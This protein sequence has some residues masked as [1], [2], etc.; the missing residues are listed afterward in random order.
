MFVYTVSYHHSVCS[1]ILH[2]H[3]VQYTGGMQ[4]YICKAV[5]TPFCIH[6][7]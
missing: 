2:M 5:C 6:I 4:W 7:L 3:K 1:R